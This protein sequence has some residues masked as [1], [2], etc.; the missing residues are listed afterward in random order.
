MMSERIRQN[1]NGRIGDLLKH[2]G[3][4]AEFRYTPEQGGRMLWFFEDGRVFTPGEC[5]DFL[6]I[7]TSEGFNNLGRG[8]PS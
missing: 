6:G 4:E 2:Q 8:W 3:I 5:A 7:P 1:L